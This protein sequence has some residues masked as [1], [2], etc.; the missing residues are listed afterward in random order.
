MDPWAESEQQ[1]RAVVV[2]D[3]DAPVHAMAADTSAEK[4][5]G[6]AQLSTGDG[7]DAADG[8]AQAED[9][10]EDPDNDFGTLTLAS[11]PTSSNPWAEPA[12]TLDRKTS[13]HS[14]GG[15]GLHETD[16]TTPA[17]GGAA[18]ASYAREWADYDAANFGVGLTQLG[19]AC[20]RYWSL[21]KAY[22]N[23]NSGAFGAC[24]NPIQEEIEASP[25]F[26]VDTTL[27]QLLRTS[28]ERIAPLL[29]V[30]AEDVV[31]VP[32]TTTAFH[33]VVRD[34]PTTFEPGDAILTV[35]TTYGAIGLNVQ[36]L[37][38]ATATTHK[39][40]NVQVPLQWPI[41]D[42]DLLK[43]V[44]DSIVQ[45]QSEQTLQA[46]GGKGRIRLAVFDAVSSMPSVRVPWEKLTALAK[47][48][49]IK[50]FIDGAHAIGHI[51]LDVGTADPDFFV[52]NC[53]KWLYA[54]RGCA[55]FYVAK[56]NQ[57]LVHGVP[58]SWLY[59]PASLRA[60]QDQEAAEGSLPVNT[61]REFAGTIDWSSYG[62]IEPALEF[63]KKLGGERRLMAYTHWLATRGGQAAAKIL[64][65]EI[66]E[67]ESDETLAAVTNDPD[68]PSTLTEDEKTA[69]S[70]KLPQR[71][72]PLTMSMVNI[73]LPLTSAVF[74]T[75]M[76]SARK[77]LLK[78]Y[79][80]RTLWEEFQTVI[81]VYEHSD[82]LFARLAG[83]VFLEVEDFEYGARALKE[84][85]K[86]LNEG[87]AELER[88]G[89]PPYHAGT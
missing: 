36:H 29:N 2:Q 65:T 17:H 51:E 6:T 83:A 26:F 13:S 12:P 40:R 68:D 85:C 54:H 44:E 3:D 10:D 42:E 32:N 57:H 82:R 72:R 38:D 56:R 48:Y 64:G 23:L 15:G 69:T 78:A 34:L 35:S 1:T 50:S 7:G 30:S 11:A 62:T 74:A 66:L 8:A 49:D 87:T 88:G 71:Q 37:V 22:T 53:H 47:K 33:S 41:K 58:I 16:G 25:D 81:P 27:P 86:R 46:R 43:A 19:H 31:F 67:L 61:W 18:A 84:V 89:K 80:F 75:N 9:E 45:D 14:G 24:P 70:S 5:A 20:A 52:S 21:K 59:S 76:S 73:R 79:V 39:F 28:R 55:V 63:R 77:G 60:K 4:P